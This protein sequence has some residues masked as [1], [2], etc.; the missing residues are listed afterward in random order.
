MLWS[1]LIQS[2]A[3]MSVSNLNLEIWKFCIKW[4]SCLKQPH[5]R[6]FFFFFLEE[7]QNVQFSQGVKTRQKMWFFLLLH[8]SYWAIVEVELKI[9]GFRRNSHSEQNIKK[10]VSDHDDLPPKK[11]ESDHDDLPPKPRL[12]W[13]AFGARR[14]KLS[15]LTKTK[16][17]LK[18]ALADMIPFRLNF[19]AICWNKCNQS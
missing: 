6:C 3:Y 7:K 18:N 15:E 11:A 12:F 8:H 1:V 9:H 19:V 14:P 16:C 2:L 17:Y 10:A 4:S 5:F 13:R